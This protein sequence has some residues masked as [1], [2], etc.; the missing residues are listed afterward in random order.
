M[1]VMDFSLL[2]G[3]RLVVQKYDFDE[4]IWIDIA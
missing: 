4:V 3:R 1:G 2:G